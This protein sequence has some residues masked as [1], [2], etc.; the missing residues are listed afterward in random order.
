[1]RLDNLTKTMLIGSGIFLGIGVLQG[2]RDLNTI[3]LYLI[4]TVLL[5]IYGKTEM[6]SPT[7]VKVFV[8]GIAVNVIYSLISIILGEFSAPIQTM[9]KSG[10]E[11]GVVTGLAYVFLGG[12]K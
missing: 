9:I 11:Q 12:R 8:L 2:L 3:A 10:L 4:L 6:R 1:M 7:L 5:A